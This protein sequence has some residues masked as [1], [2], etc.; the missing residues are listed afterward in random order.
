V[1]VEITRTVV[2]VGEV[3]VVFLL[4]SFTIVAF[5]SRLNLEPGRGKVVVHAIKVSGLV[6]V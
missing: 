3:G 1:P 5:A 4:Q 6:E 2:C